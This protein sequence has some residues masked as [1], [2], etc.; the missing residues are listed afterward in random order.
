MLISLQ[1]KKIFLVTLL[2]DL[3][4]PFQRLG[5]AIAEKGQQILG[6]NLLGLQAGIFTQRSCNFFFF[7][8]LILI[9]SGTDIVLHHMDLKIIQMMLGI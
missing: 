4:H 8:Y 6:D 7:S 5:L 1:K 2:F 3:R 9:C